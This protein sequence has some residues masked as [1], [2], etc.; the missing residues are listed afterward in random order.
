MYFAEPSVLDWN[1]M[2]AMGGQL[3]SKLTSV[4]QCTICEEC[5]FNCSPVVSSEATKMDMV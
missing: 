1:K 5:I 4:H 3:Y 2:N